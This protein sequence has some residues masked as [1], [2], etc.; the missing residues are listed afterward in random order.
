M[1]LHP[2]E[3]DTL[4]FAKPSWQS[5]HTV[6][7]KLLRMILVCYTTAM[8]AEERIEQL[9]EQLSQALERMGLLEAQLT[10]AYQR[11]EELEKQKTPP[12]PFVKANVKK[13]PA[14]QKK[15]RK[16]RDPKHNHGR[17]REAPTQIVEHPIS[18]CEGC[19]SRLGGVSVARRREVIEIPPPAGRG[20]RTSGVSRLV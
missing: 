10:A 7:L 8:T 13:A 17:R 16:R 19:G 3:N 2:R 9:E 15:P 20:H 4:W 6:S 14:E 12:P 5:I 18:T 11:I 1:M